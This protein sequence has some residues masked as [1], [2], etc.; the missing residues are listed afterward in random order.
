M[1]QRGAPGFPLDTSW[2]LVSYG[3][4]T[5]LTLID[6][7]RQEL[8]VRGGKYSDDSAVVGCVKDGE[9]TEYRELV[10]S[11]VAWCGNN[12]LLLNVAKT[13]E[14]QQ[15]W[16]NTVYTKYSEFI[17]LK[18]EVELSQS[19]NKP[20]QLA[21][22]MTRPIGIIE[23]V[24]CSC[25]AGLGKSCSHAAAVIW[26][27]QNA[28]VSGKT[29][30]A[31]TD[32]QRRWNE[33]TSK[34]LQPKRLSQ[35]HFRHHKAEDEY[36]EETRA[37]G[38]QLPNTPQYQSHKDFRESVDK[39]LTK[40]LFLLKNTLL[41]KCYNATP[42]AE[43]QGRSK[44]QGTINDLTFLSHQNHDSDLSCV[45]YQKFYQA[46]VNMDGKQADTLELEMRGQSAS[47]LWHSSRKLRIT[48]S[49][50]KKVPVRAGTNSERFCV[51][52]FTPAFVVTMPLI[53]GKK[54]KKQ[55]AAN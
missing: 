46:Y 30:L 48:A 35:I 29:G 45:K 54:K 27:V 51:S 55:L 15:N 20:K 2:T 13:K 43:Q 1:D 18:A 47:D 3:T 26:K 52:T 31:C 25:I 5:P 21:W 10:N 8:A 12:H 39:S 7:S 41:E 34:N 44:E 37:V 4:S 40:P 22:V 50:A 16:K 38:N 6:L 33:G 14:M 11:F 28:V 49:S 32:T 17:F 24:G 53:I 36:E 23:T 19:I 9:D 42:S